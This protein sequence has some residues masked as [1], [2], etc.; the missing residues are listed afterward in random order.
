M[1]HYHTFT[2]ERFEDLQIRWHGGGT[3]QIWVHYQVPGYF[4]N[5]GWTE[6]D[7]FTH[8]GADCNTDTTT[9]E[10]AAIVAEHFNE[11]AEE[12]RAEY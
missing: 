8:Y 4:S 10:A 6:T 2:D 11:M 9:D 5:N 1:E 3:Y 7:C 12:E